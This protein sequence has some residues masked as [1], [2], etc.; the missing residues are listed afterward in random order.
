M[1]CRDVTCAYKAYDVSVAKVLI[2]VSRAVMM[3]VNSKLKS[4]VSAVEIEGA[5]ARDQR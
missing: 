4:K 3:M 5:Q 2:E 1:G